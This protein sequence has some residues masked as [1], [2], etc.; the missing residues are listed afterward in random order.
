[1]VKVKLSKPKKYKMIIALVTPAN[2]GDKTGNSIT[3]KRW[4][5]M[6][7]MLGYKVSIMHTFENENVDLMIAL[8]A[9]RS[10]DSISKF[11]S[12]FPDKPLVV[13]LTGTDLYRFLDSNQEETMRSISAANRLVVLNNLSQN[14]LPED[15]RQKAY[16]IYESA[17]NLPKGRLPVQQYFDICVIGHLRPEKDPLLTAYSVR[18]LPASSKIRIRHYGKAHTNEWAEKARTEMSQNPRYTWFGEVPHW[19]I[20]QAL[21]KCNLLVLSSKVEGGPNV[22]SEAIVAGVP[23]VTTNIDGCLGVLGRDYP[24]YF[25]VGDTQALLSLLNKAEND[26]EFLFTL[27]KFIAKIASQFGFQE[28]K[29]RWAK[30]LIELRDGFEMKTP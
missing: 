26:S 28:E 1:M 4:V 17:E 12:K 2:L 14:V 18:N 24:G 25:P 22:L 13:A 19:R 29:S 9:Y 7:R 23:V 16:L 30:L 15:Q 21:S 20:R 27:E 8:N 10:R 3:A 6:F 5:S 11:R